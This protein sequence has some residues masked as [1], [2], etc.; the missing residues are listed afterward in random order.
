MYKPQHPYPQRFKKKALDEKFSTFLDIFKKIH[1]NIPFADALE[2][3]P[4]YSKFV[5]DVMSKK[6][7]LQDNKV[8][9]LTEECS[10]ILQKKFPQKFK[11]PGSFT[12]FCFIGGAK[13]N[14]ALCD[15][16]AIINLMPF[17]VYKTLELGE[18]K[19]TSITLQLEDRSITYPRGIVED[20]LVKVD[21]FI[22]PAEFVILDMD[23]DK[24]TPLIFGRPFLATARA[25]IDVHKGSNDPLERFLVADEAFDKDEDWER[26]EQEAFLEGAPKEKRVSPKESEALENS[27]PVVSCGDLGLAGYCYYR[28]LDDYSGYNQILIALEDQEK[29]TFT[30][31]Y[32]T[33]SFR[34]MP[35]G[36]CNALKTFQRC[37]MEIFADM[38]D[39]VMEALEKINKA[40]TTTPIM[41]VSDWKEPFELMC[42]ANDYAVGAALG[43][44][45]EKMFR[46][47]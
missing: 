29:T 45:R 37:I 23:E 33:F 47:I 5:K 32:G 11:D 13:V 2:Q 1:I 38:V 44:W 27:A 40:L 17:F 28:F 18:V 19:A 3:M 10:A 22:F 12:I 4:N 25:L 16:G 8:V 21:K 26:R 15:L 36:L 35:F 24:E 7:R 43:Q 30:C 34:R 14:R 41:I 9:N 39:D 20:I 46:A 31:P 6:R 42:D